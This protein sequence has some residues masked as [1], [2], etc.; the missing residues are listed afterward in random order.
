MN[1]VIA[2]NSSDERIPVSHC[3]NTGK[4]EMN[5]LEYSFSGASNRAS[6][7][8]EEVLFEREAKDPETGSSV[9]RRVS[10]SFSSKYG[11][12]TIEDD[13]VYVGFQALTYDR[14]RQGC[15]S[16]RLTVR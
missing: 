3:C 11:R 12:P 6:R 16:A 1:S 5:L 14:R 13:Q 4:D 15:D 9:I 2:D 10:M 8:T 7:S